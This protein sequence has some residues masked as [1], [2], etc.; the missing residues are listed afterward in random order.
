MARTVAGHRRMIASTVKLRV[1]A[2]LIEQSPVVRNG[3][4]EPV[5]RAFSLR[6]DKL[7]GDRVAAF[8]RS[9][10]S[11]SESVVLTAVGP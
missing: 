4:N 2:S 10:K 6:H 11:D 3:N 7:E 1:P 8:L 9:G 5:S